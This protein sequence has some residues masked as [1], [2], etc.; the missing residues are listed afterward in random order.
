MTVISF[1]EALDNAEKIVQKSSKQGKKHLLLG[2]GFSIACDPNIFNY[3]S[4]YGAARYAHFGDIPNA[5]HVFDAFNTED[6]EFIIQAL[7][8]AAEVLPAFN[9]EDEATVSE[10]SRQANILKTA[11]VH[12]IA[13]KHPAKP[14][15]I[16]EERFYACR[17]FLAN[18]IGGHLNKPGQV[19]TLNYDLLLYW[20][21][22]HDDSSFEKEE[23]YLKINDGFGRDDLSKDEESE[24]DY[25]TWQGETN[26]NQNIHYLHG[27]VHLFDAGTELKKYIWAKTGTPLMEQARA[28]MGK[29]M[30][31]LFVAEGTSQQ[32]LDKIKHHA[33]LHHSYKSFARQMSQSHNDVLFI[34]GHSL[35]ENDKHILDKISNG[36]IPHVFISLYGDENSETNQSIKHA[37]ELIQSKRDKRYPLAITYFD[38]KSAQVWGE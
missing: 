5:K 33:F 25:V 34:Y 19:Y 24:Q 26:H 23:I 38:A 16:S 6:F 4:L 2:N 18:F 12:A 15:D 35:A 29:D 3:A 10:I 8:N 32:K 21:V 27:A 30:F 14:N 22:M 9:P 1:E 28:A 31:P 36:K 20:A 7:E 17:K 37:A 13:D 11:L